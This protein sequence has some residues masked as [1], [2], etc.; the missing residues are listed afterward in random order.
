M[1]FDGPVL[2]TDAVHLRRFA[3]IP[4]LSHRMVEWLGTLD[5]AAGSFEPQSDS[6][7]VTVKIPKKMGS[8]PRGKKPAVYVGSIAVV[9]VDLDD[10]DQKMRFLEFR[11]DRD[12]FLGT[13]EIDT[14]KKH[15]QRAVRER[16]SLTMLRR[17][18]QLEM[19]LP[20]V[21]GWHFKV[22][23]YDASIADIINRNLVNPRQDRWVFRVRM[24]EARDVTNCGMFH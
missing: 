2:K 23:P 16:H 4:P 8:G 1:S 20:A 6:S 24:N 12:E 19:W 9:Q 10:L 14:V 3:I 17:H 11:F 5:E 7:A 13:F 18:F 22:M 21:T 15:V